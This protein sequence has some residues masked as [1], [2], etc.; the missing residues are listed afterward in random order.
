M[1]AKGTQDTGKNTSAAQRFI[2][3]KES[4][5]VFTFLWEK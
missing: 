1:F 5:R 4:R 3:K 2:E